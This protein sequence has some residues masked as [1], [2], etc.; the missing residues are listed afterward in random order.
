MSEDF[1][2]MI[3][4]QTIRTYRRELADEYVPIRRAKLL[5]L[6]ARARMAA[7][8]HGWPETLG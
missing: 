6:I 4:H 2:E 1:A 8:D 7:A 5:T 3:H